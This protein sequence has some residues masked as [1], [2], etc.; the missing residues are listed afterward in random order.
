MRSIAV[1]AALG[2]IVACSSSGDKGP[3]QRDQIGQVWKYE[4]GEGGKARSPISAAPTRS[5]P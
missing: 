5:R 1:L 3:T 2:L 4:G